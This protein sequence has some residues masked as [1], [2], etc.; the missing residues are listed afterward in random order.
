VGLRNEGKGSA[1]VRT[2]RVKGNGGN[3]IE[4]GWIGSG[5]SEATDILRF[6]DFEVFENFVALVYE[7]GK[8]LG[9]TSQSQYHRLGT[10]EQRLP[11]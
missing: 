5:D 2:A 4:N 7:D 9:I 10:I 11:T 1:D 8:I 3:E 6:R